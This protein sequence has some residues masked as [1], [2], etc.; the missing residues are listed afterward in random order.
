MEDFVMNERVSRL[1]NRLYVENY[2]L[3]IEKF[4][5]ITESLGQT[6][7]EPEI[8]RRAKTLANVLDN[9]TIMIEDDE[10]IVGNV[11]S[12]PM[13]LEIDH[14]YGTWSQEEIDSLKKE[15]Y[16]ISKEDEEELIILNQYYKGKSLVGRMGEILFDDERLWP[17]MQ[18]G[19]V[20]PPWKS[21]GEGSGGGYAQGGMGLGPGF[22][23]LGVDFTIVLN[24]GLNKLIEEAE[25]ELK[26][27]R[28][29]SAD[30]IKKAYFLKSVIITQKAII[31]FAWRFADLAAE[32]AQRETNPDR[33]KELE[34]IAETCRRVPAQPARSF[35]EAI[36][37]FWFIFLMIT[38]SP[39]AAAGRFDQY[40]YPFYMKDIEKGSID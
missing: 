13:G 30:S 21:K 10:L 37:S 17:F 31:R 3:C 8:L 33:K 36:Q 34:R 22:Y 4:R 35:Y 23:L 9:I 32:M 29:N 38:P 12:K 40:M 5:L 18:S 25:E 6:E 19:V 28:Y 7:G 16:I 14:D 24:S 26:I 27:M 39:T 20:L 2:P 1:K 11:A 15:G